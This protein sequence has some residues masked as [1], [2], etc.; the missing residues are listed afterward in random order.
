[1]G[2]TE[3]NRDGRGSIPDDGDSGGPLHV[4]AK[5]PLIGTKIY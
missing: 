4:V 3:G 2:F 5:T 1:M